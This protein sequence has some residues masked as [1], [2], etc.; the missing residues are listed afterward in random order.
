M[1]K[2]MACIDFTEGTD[3][4][5]EKSIELA[6][7][8]N[9]ALCLIHVAP[10]KRE[11]PESVCGK[12]SFPELARRL[13]TCNRHF[14][15]VAKRIKKAGIDLTTVRARGE[16]GKVIA[17]EVIKNKADMIIMGAKNNSALHHLVA[18][19]VAADVM[20]T[21]NAPVVLIPIPIT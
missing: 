20:R 2:I 7:A 18:G 14:D 19:S 9:A 12:R 15:D 3:R 16:A 1:N 6:A 17:H 4:I 10:P 13:C 21:T 5:I 11:Q 8:T